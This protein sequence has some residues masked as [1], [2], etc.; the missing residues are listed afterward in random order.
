MIFWDW[1]IIIMKEKQEVEVQNTGDASAEQYYF[2]KGL[3]LYELQ[4]ILSS[5]LRAEPR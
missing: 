5:D 3:Y 1:L 2:V 4:T